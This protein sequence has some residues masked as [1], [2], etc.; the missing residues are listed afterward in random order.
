VIKYSNIVVLL[1][2]LRFFKMVVC[3]S[4]VKIAYLTVVS[5]I[6]VRRG[7][8][9]NALP[10]FRSLSI[11]RVLVFQLEL[12]LGMINGA[13]K[14][15]AYMHRSTSIVVCCIKTRDEIIRFSAALELGMF[16]TTAGGVC[17]DR[18]E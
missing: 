8:V 15:Q 18:R 16:S 12:L 9:T 7:G 1:V 10:T 6:A 5:D 13:C 17:A 11:S 2:L 3:D 14:A 4:S